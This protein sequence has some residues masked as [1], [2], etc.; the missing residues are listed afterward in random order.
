MLL[1]IETSCDDTCAAIFD[2]NKKLLSSVVSSQHDVHAEFQGVVP[3]LASRRHCEVIN[4]ILK[5]TLTQADVRLQDLT[6]VAVTYGPGLIGSLLT[7]IAAAKS[8]AACFDLPLLAVNHIEAHA[9][10][11]F[12]EHKPDYPYISLVASGGHSILLHVK[13]DSDYEILGHTR[14]DAAGEA[15]DKTAKMLNLGYPGG[16]AIQKLAAQGNPAG[17]DFPRP[18]LTGTK[19]WN[20]RIEDYDFSFSGLKTAVYYYWMKNQNSNPADIAASFQQ[21]VNDCLIY[22]T[23]RAAQ[24]LNVKNICLGGG[25]AANSALRDDFK[26]Q[27]EKQGM[28][29][30]FPELKNCTDNAA[31]VGMRALIA[32]EKT[33]LK[34]NARPNLSVLSPKKEKQEAVTEA[35][36]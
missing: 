27:A 31:M 7:G 11:V 3:E 16:P 13:S 22:K 19:R 34:L 9:Y 33:D 12:L 17:I 1:A 2:S 15:Y 25:V 36:G 26:E 20:W 30:Y 10:S 21:A 6:R 4:F 8:I 24:E 23:I 18:T 14:D 32:P 5:K 28:T 29:V 35:A